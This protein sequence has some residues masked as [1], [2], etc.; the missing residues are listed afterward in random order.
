MDSKLSR[1]RFCM[2]LLFAT[3][4]LLSKDI[5]FPA[6]ANAN[7]SLKERNFGSSGFEGINV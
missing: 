6:P 4:G 3:T 1:R 2:N 5:L 7:E